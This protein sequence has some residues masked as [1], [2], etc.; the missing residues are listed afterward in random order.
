VTVADLEVRRHEIPISTLEAKR[1]G[2]EVGGEPWGRGGMLFRRPVCLTACLPRHADYSC[3]SHLHAG[4]Y[5]LVR[6]S[7]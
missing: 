4:Q 5:I 3:P 7:R 2:R 1:G 6:S